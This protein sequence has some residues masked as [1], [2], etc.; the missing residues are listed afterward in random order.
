[1]FKAFFKTLNFMLKDGISVLICTHNGSKNLPQT[2]T[3]LAQQKVNDDLS[4]E[5]ILIDNCSTD[6]SKE[7][8]LSIWKDLDCPT[9][10]FLYDEPLLGKD[11]A[12]DLG[13]SKVQHGYV[14][15]CD[16]DN[17]LC[18]T[19]VTHA[20]HIMKTNPDIGLLGGKS[21]ASFESTPP[22][23]F[24]SYQTYFAVGSQNIVSGEIHHYWPKHRFLW[25]A[26]SVINMQAYLL[27]KNNGFSRI[28]T[29]NKYSKVARSEDVELCFAIW[30][31]G[32]KIW[33]ENELVL[34][35]NISNDRLK[36]GYLMKIIKQSISS[37]HYLRPYQIF[38]FSGDRYIP[39][40]SFWLDYI[41]YY[42]K[43]F[44]KDWLSLKGIKILF[45]LLTGKHREEDYYYFNRAI[46][47]YQ[48]TSVLCLGRGYDKIFKRVANLNH[49]LKRT[50]RANA[51]N[52]GDRGINQRKNSDQYSSMISN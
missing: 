11:I 14:I 38:I 8:A 22:S 4:W 28:L 39:T 7:I 15:I 30:L 37:M 19:Y 31:A 21:I 35:H 41:K 12:V 3:Y 51:K 5:V 10:L 52:E 36:W 25:G 2:L 40:D 20:Y 17:W 23:W 24:S 9:P 48:F 44:F 47:W 16:D 1:L 13:L 46:E 42:G 32:Y 26:G 33:Y 34:Q 6:N 49:Q 45:R 50:K 43:K 29:V 27:L 18:N